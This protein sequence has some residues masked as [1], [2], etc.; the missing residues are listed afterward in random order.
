MFHRNRSTPDG[1]HRACKECKAAEAKK[2][3]ENHRKELSAR[4]K[5]Y[6]KKNASRIK[7]VKHQYY[8]KNRDEIFKKV[9]VW[10]GNNAAKCRAY[11]AKA[12]NKLKNQVFSHYCGGD[13]RCKWCGETDLY[14][15]SIDHIDGGGG[16]HRRQIGS[17]NKGGYNFYRWLKRNNYPDGFQVLCFNCQY[18]KRMVEMKPKNPTHLQEVRAKY[19]RRVKEQCFDHY[20]HHC[21]CGETDVV[22]LT[23]DHVN[24]DGVSHR[25]ETG[26]K[27][28][29]FYILLRKNNFPT[30]PPLQVMCMNCQIKKRKIY[31]EKRA[32]DQTNDS[33]VAAIVV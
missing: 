10:R 3:R 23:L 15:L 5:L 20:G 25:K 2:F 24:D 4:D 9:V 27:G 8:L 12:K 13:V 21:P 7:K 14:I 1:L 26:V 29:G 11:C 19:A 33:D 30:D 17:G 18:R 22:V 32:L 6:W 16:R 31:Y 28:Y